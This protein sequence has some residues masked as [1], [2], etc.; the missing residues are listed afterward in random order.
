MCGAADSFNLIKL[1]RQILRKRNWKYHKK[2]MLMHTLRYIPCMI[3]GHKAYIVED[4]PHCHGGYIEWACEQC[5]CYI[6][7]PK[8]A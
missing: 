1:P 5:R 2:D 7:K 3:F 6:D 4:E 8:W